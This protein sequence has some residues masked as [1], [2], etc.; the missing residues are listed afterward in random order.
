MSHPKVSIII[1]NWN[2]LEDTSECIESL[3]K[4]TYPN[5]EVIVVDNASEG[6][7]VQALSERFGDYIQMVRNDRNYGCGEG[8]NSGIRY[9]LKNSQ[10]EYFLLLNNDVVVAPAFLSELVKVAESDAHIGIV[11]PKIYYY[12]YN[13][14]K[15]VIWS[16]GGKTRWWSPIMHR[17]IGKNDDDLPKYQTV[18]SMNWV[19][20][21]VLMLKSKLIEKVGLLNPWYFFSHEDI[22]YCLKARRL[23][24]KV[25]YV[26]SAK[27]WHKVGASAKKA[28]I[29]YFSPSAYYYL[30]KQNFPLVVYIYHLLLSPIVL[31][32]WASLHLV[33]YRD[34]RALRWFLTDLIRFVSQWRRQSH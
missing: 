22:E 8:Y 17:Q 34:I 15:D 13:G 4:V 31:S 12:D 33:R 11:G 25:I 1:P 24:F 26:P 18:R 29:T 2:G 3:K 10:P 30:I 20:G 9:A 27:V 28:H 6:N 5:Y 32:I 23:G 14:R 21:T 7:D 16:V 19:S